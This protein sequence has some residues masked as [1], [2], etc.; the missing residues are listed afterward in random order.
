MII[1][2][3]AGAIKTLPRKYEEEKA[4][5][6]G[7]GLSRARRM[8]GAKEI[9]EVASQ[10]LNEPHIPRP[11]PGANLRMHDGTRLTF[12]TDGS[13]R[14]SYGPKPKHLSGRQRVKVRKQLRRLR[15]QE[16]S[17]KAAA[18]AGAAR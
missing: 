16:A 15:K 2:K 6:E 17:R 3:I 11:I 12:F 1:D 14:N 8:M 4:K 7:R 18:D 10:L 9:K 13:L 5:L